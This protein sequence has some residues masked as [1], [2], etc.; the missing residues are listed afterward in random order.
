[1]KQALIVWGGWDGHEPRQ[2]A[3]IMET[4]LVGEGFS[5][6]VATTL[7]AFLDEEK[8]KS[9]DLIVPNWTMG[10][11]TGEQLAPLLNAIRAGVGCGGIHGGMGDAFRDFAL[12]D[13]A[14][15]PSHVYFGLGSALVA[16][17]VGLL[18]ALFAIVCHH[19]L[20]DR[21]NL[22]ITEV[23]ILSERLLKRACSADHGT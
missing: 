17:Q 10:A 22:V 9:L 2:T 15:D 8:L 4:A 5:V 13:A 6:E 12:Q 7:D 3:E 1:M 19:V 18:I 20:R 11:I 21:M 14:P 16:T 23:G